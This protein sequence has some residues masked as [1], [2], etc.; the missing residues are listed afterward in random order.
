MAST[1]ALVALFSSVAAAEPV[2]RGDL[3]GHVTGHHHTGFPVDTLGTELDAVTALGA[4]VRVR[5][6]AGTDGSFD[7]LRLRF[8]LG[9]DLAA[10]TWLGRPALE[11]DELPGS[12]HAPGLLTEA[13]TRIEI[14]PWVGLQG[15]L[16]LSHWGL[17]LVANA[18]DDLL[19]GRL[20]H[21]LFET[22]RPGDRLIRGALFARPFASL[23]DSPL[24]GLVLAGALDR[25]EA[26]DTSSAA[27]GDETYQGVASVRLF[28]APEEWLGVYYVYR[29]QTTAA[30]KSVRAHVVDVAGDLRFQPA[31]GHTLRL[32]A[33]LVGIFGE[34][35][36][37]PSPEHPVHDILQLG[38]LARLRW[39]TSLWPLGAE[40]DL[41]VFSGDGNLDDGRLTRFVADRNL[42]QG[43]VLFPTVLGWQ[44]GR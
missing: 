44:T 40:V 37:A 34:T 15:G 21:R 12:A 11:G 4:R 20:R 30:G 1:I 35:N 32:Q 29:D 3:A 26:D 17:G 31:P 23:P 25:V 9:G 10:G 14:G 38:G 28:V 5:L 6:E 8:R 42:Q 19:D 43:M 41:G 27:E 2:F 18:G 39:E 24:R 13:F 36:L 7:A 33:E 16:M 22:S